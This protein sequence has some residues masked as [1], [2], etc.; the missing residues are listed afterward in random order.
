MRPIRLDALSAEQLREL[1]ELYH[2]TRDVRVGGRAQMI[3]LVAEQGMVAAEIA[4]IV[5]QG[6]ETAR[7][8]LPATWPRA[9]RASPTRRAPGRRR[10]R[11]R[12]TASASSGS[13]AAGPGRSACRSRSGPRHAWPTT[14]PS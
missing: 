3:L 12:R 1:D 2:T 7:R 11:R 13:R 8:W 10:R 6:E 4:A 9:S 5:R 14:W